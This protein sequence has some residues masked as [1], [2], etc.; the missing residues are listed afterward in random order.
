MRWR[1]SSRIGLPKKESAWRAEE[2]KG[3]RRM[4]EAGRPESREEVGNRAEIFGEM[5][6]GQGVAVCWTD[7][8]VQL[9][10]DRHPVMSRGPV[11]PQAPTPSM[12]SDSNRE[13]RQVIKSSPPMP[14]GVIAPP[15][16][17]TPVSIFT[18]TADPPSLSGT[19]SHPFRRLASGPARMVR[20]VLRMSRHPRNPH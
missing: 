2:E 8:I 5:E 20:P 1:W 4:A 17:S 16:A 6:T 13:P 10:V 12:I 14:G 15:L 11:C 19:P 3:G 7:P 9:Q 18:S